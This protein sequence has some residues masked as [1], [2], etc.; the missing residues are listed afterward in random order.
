MLIMKKKN[1]IWSTIKVARV[2]RCLRNGANLGSKI[3][4]GDVFVMNDNH[5]FAL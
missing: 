3:L 4:Y 2:R 5:S 1:I